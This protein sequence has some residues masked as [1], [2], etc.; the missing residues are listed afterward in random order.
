ML[1]NQE[2]LA[3]NIFDNN[4]NFILISYYNAP[5]NS[6]NVEVLK[7]VYD[8]YK[9]VIVI[10]DLNAKTKNLGCNNTNK[11]GE[12]LEELVLE[13]NILIANN[14]EA[15]YSRIHD[16]SNDILD[17]CLISSNM[18]DEFISFDVLDKR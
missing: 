13:S 10:G 15:T 16:K 14:N 3:I 6:L 4:V 17:W 2:C 1:E 5:Q 7:E 9:K 8:K 18:H 11:N 12:L